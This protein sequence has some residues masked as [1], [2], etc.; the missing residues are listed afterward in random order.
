[1]V[2]QHRSR[3]S[4]TTR[5][6]RRYRAA[7]ASGADVVVLAQSD[8][9]RRN[10]G[11]PPHFREQHG[12][13][14]RRCVSSRTFRPTSSSPA[15]AGG[16]PHRQFIRGDQGCLFLGT[17]AVNIGGRQQGR[18]AADRVLHVGYDSE[19]I[20]SAVVASSVTAATPPRTSTIDRMP[21]RRLSTSWPASSSTPR[22]AS[23][24]PPTTE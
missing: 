18:L 20:R 4:G 13:A 8:A 23:T 6:S 17:P 5:A 16:V 12:A 24:N 7:S 15:P 1:M 2:I 21:A 3:P 14:P 19:A 10:G 9:G 11:K 22:N